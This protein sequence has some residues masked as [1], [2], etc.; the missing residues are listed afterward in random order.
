MTR[1]PW[2]RVNDL[3]Q[4]SRPTSIGF[5][6]DWTY[7]SV[8][9]DGA[10]RNRGT[11]TTNGRELIAYAASNPCDER[12]RSN[13]EQITARFLS[14]EE[15]LLQ[16]ELHVPRAALPEHGL[17][18]KLFG[19]E[20]AVS[21]RVEYPRPLRRGRAAIFTF[22]FLNESNEDLTLERVAL[23]STF[24]DY[25]YKTRGMEVPEIAA[26]DLG[27]KRLA[28]HESYQVTLDATFA[29]AGPTFVYFDV[30]VAGSQQNW[31]VRQA[32][33]VRIAP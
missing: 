28:P 18:R 20:N 27:R 8:Y 21:T 14:G 33:E 1:F 2:V 3:D 29:A 26:L 15:L 24:R 22:T 13:D 10:C 7:E 4:G 6:P 23:N 11:W 32:H 12:D 25:R 31:D 5:A 30:L 9:R 17:I 19:Y 16:G